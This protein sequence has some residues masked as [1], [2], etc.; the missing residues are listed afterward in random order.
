MSETGQHHPPAGRHVV[1]MAGVFP[2]LSETFVYREAVALR[3]RGWRI[4]PVSLNE[5]PPGL[6][7][8]RR[9][10]LV[11]YS[12]L[13]T[14]LSAA[15]R[16]MARA[17]VASL[18]TLLLALGD[19]GAPG[20]PTPVS[21][22]L[23]LPLQALAAIALAG[24]LRQRPDHVHCHFAHA[25]TTVGMYLAHHLGIGFSFTGHANDL[26]QRRALLR[27]KLRR[28][29]FVCCISRWHREHY[30][31]RHDTDPAKCVIVRCGVDVA[32]ARRTGRD[33]P[34]TAHTTTGVLRAL[35]ICRLVEK[36]GIDTL[37]RAIVDVPEAA[38]TV[39]GDG[40]MRHKL[41][42][43]AADLRLADRV[44]WLGAV[45]N[46]RVPALLSA[47]DVVVLPCRTDARGDRDGIPVALIEAMAAGVPVIA[48]DLPAI[49]ELVEHNTTGLLVDGADPAS[50]AQALQLMRSV[51]LRKR[52]ASAGA[53]HAAAE[54][55]QEINIDRLEAALD[56][57]LRDRPVTL[58]NA[59][60]GKPLG[61]RVT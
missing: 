37:L 31:T 48:G 44:T 40:P 35:T 20:E 38:L 17:P 21:L 54:F 29:R 55:S 46:D 27:T 6:A 13:V 58:P 3:Q 24:R 39:A 51:D 36:K 43:M 15:I 1:Y 18:H 5:P 19:A 42:Q 23:K 45:D 30:I 4:T 50:V 56:A 26:F 57:A 49:R 7:E 16:R 34:P 33:D 8:H 11:V 52:L 2:T 41:V 9:G 59:P 53:R 60:A 61:V 28:A 14:L 10:L 47:A 25:P 22:R 32:W 12:G